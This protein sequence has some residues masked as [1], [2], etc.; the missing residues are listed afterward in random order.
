MDTV[1]TRPKQAK[2]RCNCEWS[3][4][5]DHDVLLSIESDFAAMA[6]LIESVVTWD[7]LCHVYNCED[8]IGHDH[9]QREVCPW[10]L[11]DFAAQ[12]NWLDPFSVVATMQNLR[13]LYRRE[14]GPVDSSIVQLDAQVRDLSALAQSLAERIDSLAKV[15]GA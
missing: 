15:V 9:T 10:D 8:E 13:D 1:Q 11:G 7:E 6:T 5:R 4:C 14:T 2:G 12:H 3:D